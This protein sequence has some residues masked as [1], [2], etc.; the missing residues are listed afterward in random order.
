MHPSINDPI[1]DRIARFGF[2]PDVAKKI[3]QAKRAFVVGMG[4]SL[5][6][7]DPSGL[8]DELVV[9]VNYALRTAFTPDFICVTDNRRFDFES[10]KKSG[11][12]VITIRQLAARRINVL[13]Q[14]NC[15]YDIDHVEYETLSKTVLDQDS[16]DPRLECV[17]HGGSVIADLAIPVLTYLGV[18]EVYVLGLDGAE[19]SFPTS[20]VWGHDASIPPPLPSVIFHLHEKTASLA[21]KAGTTVMN[22]SPGG[23]VAAFQKVNMQTVAPQAWRRHVSADLDGGYIAYMDRVL[24]VKVVEDGIVRLCDDSGRYLRHRAGGLRIDKEEDTSLFLADSSFIAEPSFVNA[25]WILLRTTNTKNG[26]VT[27][28]NESSGYRLRPTQG[29]FSPYFSSFRVFQ[30]KENAASRAEH[31]RMLRNLSDIRRSIGNQMTLSD[32]IQGL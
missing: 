29:V 24:C 9:G 18:K 5:A 19:A 3:K 20:H 23:V 12:K 8:R 21:K 11:A 30:N 15:Y 32:R 27:A 2:S 26:F 1:E 31:N 14:I 16:Y 7:I 22:A 6:K 17:Y 28:M 13:D 10:Y 4:P 25:D